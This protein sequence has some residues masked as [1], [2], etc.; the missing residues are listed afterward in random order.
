MDQK[1][2]R[3]WTLFKQ[4]MLPVLVCRLFINFTNLKDFT[5]LNSK[6]VQIEMKAG[7]KIHQKN[8]NYFFSAR[9]APEII[10]VTLLQY[11]K[12]ELRKHNI[13]EQKVI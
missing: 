5:V 10:W 4:C 9:L 8:Y 1:K 11:Y 3:I 6:L 13:A 7:A 12:T 2:L